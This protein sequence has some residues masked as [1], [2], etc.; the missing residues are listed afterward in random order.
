MTPPRLATRPRQTPE[1]DSHASPP[2]ASAPDAPAHAMTPQQTATTPPA[3]AERILLRFDHPEPSR[4]TH[5]SRPSIVP[6]FLP[7]AGCPQRC[8]FC[9]Q[10]AQTGQA[11]KLVATCA[12]TGYRPARGR[13]ERMIAFTPPGVVRG[14]LKDSPVLLVL[15]TGHGLTPEVLTRA[16]AIVSPVRGFSAY[17]HL[18]V[19]SAAAILVDR[20][21]GDAG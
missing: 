5:A 3:K 20:L 4:P 18:P 14:W 16:D 8:I 12:R 15:G 17:N 9:D 21:L 2:G 10:P 13:K 11:P 1:R 19:R 7:F 6:V